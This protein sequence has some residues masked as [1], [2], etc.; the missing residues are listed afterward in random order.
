P[1]FVVNPSDI[2]REYGADTLRLYEMFMGPLEVS[3]PWNKDGVAGS[4]RFLGRVWNFMTEP[5]NLTEENDDKLTKLYHQTVKKVT[6]DFEVLHFNTAISQMMI[7]MNECY[8][9]GSCPKEYAEGIVKMLSCIT[10]HIGEEMWQRMGH[11][12][13]IAFEPW[14]VFDA[15]KAKDDT[16]EIPVQINGKLRGTVSAAVEEDADSV[17]EKVWQIEAVQKFT[18]GKTVAMEKYVK[19]R[20]YTI[21]VK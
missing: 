9:N 8:K 5:A 11:E 18:E 1:E 2:V 6:E 20:I 17:K 3:K 4:R 16:V 7:F 12:G 19:G 13:T 15:E 10:P 14:P 21:V